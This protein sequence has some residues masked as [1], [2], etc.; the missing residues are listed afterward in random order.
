LTTRVARPNQHVTPS[1]DDGRYAIAVLGKAFDLLDAISNLN[2]PTLSELS[3][4]TGQSRPTTLR[5]L[6]NLVA[7]GFA[8]RDREGRY[9][10]GL[11]LLQLGG[12]AAADLDLRTVSRPIMEGL[13][14]EVNETVNL[15][16]PTAGGI[17]YIDILESERDLRM[18]A[19]VGMRDAFHS[20]ALG[21]AM[22]S[23]FPESTVNSA[24]GPEPF[25]QKTSKTLTTKDALRQD[26]ARVRALGFAVDDEENEP[27]ARCLA[28]P[29][30][31]QRRECVGAVS[32]SGPSSR[33]TPERIPDLAERV[34]RAADAISRR[35]GY[36]GT[37]D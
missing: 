21:K 31:D 2:A 12:R 24:V 11:K 17:V 35:L 10:L 5:L 25:P 28:A 29:I 27:G 15:A 16:I 8:E 36:P 26:I 19:T 33:I 3:D 7:R 32:V 30:I 18:A 23:R 37:G 4:A 34:L 14:A 22:L 6:S 1:S 9:H 13:H 20:S